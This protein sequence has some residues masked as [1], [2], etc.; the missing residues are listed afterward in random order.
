MPRI[1]AAFGLMATVSLCI[2]F[3]LY[4]YPK[5]W[6]MVAPARAAGNEPKT[7][8]KA[9]ADKDK[10]SK[11]AAKL[12]PAAIENPTWQPFEE[13]D[14][15]EEKAAKKPA[16]RPAIPIAKSTGGAQ[17]IK[18][19]PLV[20]SKEPA[21]PGQRDAKKQG[22]KSED[23][24]TRSDDA[25]SA[26]AEATPKYGSSFDDNRGESDELDKSATPRADN[27]KRAKPGEAR[28]AKNATADK[29][30]TQSAKKPAEHKKS[31]ESHDYAALPGY[32]ADRFNDS[33]TTDTSFGKSGS[34]YGN[35]ESSFDRGASSSH[36]NNND[37]T[38]DK[39][40]GSS[41]QSNSGSSFD[42]S[43]GSSYDSPYGDRASEPAGDRSAGGST[44]R[45]ERLPSVDNVTP[46]PSSPYAVVP[47]EPLPMYPS[48]GR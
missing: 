21:K 6:D 37:S 15:N 47:G 4:R 34:S 45:L 3:N 17:S 44:S 42:K 38:Y 14:D 36:K 32:G 41:Y 39:S 30:K 7:V 9:S 48:T 22:K 18:P 28:G 31:E 25:D 8:A 10:A 23:S 43:P 16:S 46:G 12:T 11:P 1:A 40:T 20:S 2:G 13:K 27:T 24:L 26:T 29:G 35:P 19:I 5:V 33:G